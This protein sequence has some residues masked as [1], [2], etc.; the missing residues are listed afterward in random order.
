MLSAVIHNIEPSQHKNK[1]N[2]QMWN[3]NQRK[4]TENA[5]QPRWKPPFYHA[6]R[7]INMFWFVGAINIHLF[8]YFYKFFKQFE[9]TR[10]LPNI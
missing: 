6:I 10:H 9:N 4:Y 1:Q 2:Q 7:L 5:F 3:Q 8:I